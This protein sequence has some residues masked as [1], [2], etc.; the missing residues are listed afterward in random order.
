M[1]ND[2]PAARRTRREIVHREAKEYRR[3][4]PIQVRS[5]HSNSAMAT[6]ENLPDEERP[7]ALVDVKVAIVCP[8]VGRHWSDEDVRRAFLEEFEQRS[9]WLAGVLHHFRSGCGLKRC[10]AMRT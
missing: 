1:F 2:L 7:S 6:H 4:C 5:R 9:Q 8:R 3:N 10:S